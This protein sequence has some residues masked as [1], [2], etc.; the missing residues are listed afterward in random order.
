M[1][2]AAA[3]EEK[4]V[5]CPEAAPTLSDALT[6]HWPGVPEIPEVSSES[7]PET[8]QSAEKRTFFGFTERFLA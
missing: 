5:E 6:Q 2:C 8:L 7:V 3:V 1:K 4:V